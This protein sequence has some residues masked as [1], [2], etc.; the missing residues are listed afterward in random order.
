MPA[1]PS[2]SQQK[3]PCHTSPQ[4]VGVLETWIPFINKTKPN[5]KTYIKI[6]R[7]HKNI[8]QSLR[9]TLSLTLA[10]LISSPILLAKVLAR[11]GSDRASA[12]SPTPTWP[13]R[14]EQQRRTLHMSSSGFGFLVSVWWRTCSLTM[15]GFRTVRAYSR[16][17]FALTRPG[18]LEKTA[19]VMQSTAVALQ[20]GE[21]ENV[22]VGWPAG[23]LKY[24]LIQFRDT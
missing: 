15:E 6:R 11:P 4:C 19:R 18:Q 16:Q 20:G 3:A 22:V 2:A 23:K 10:S 24:A 9:L 1:T 13:L 7:V 5:R 14:C 21:L 12:I 8:P 17:I